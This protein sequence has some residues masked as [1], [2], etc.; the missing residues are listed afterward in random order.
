LVPSDF[1][2]F[3]R[4]CAKAFSPDLSWFNH[5]YNLK[6]T[7]VGKVVSERRNEK[8]KLVA[9]LSNDS[10]KLKHDLK[11]AHASNLELENRITELADSLKKCQEE[12]KLAEA[13]LRDSKK[14]HEKL[15]KI[16]EDDLKMTENLHRDVDKSTTTID[17]LRSTNVEIS[18]KNTEL[19]KTLSMKEQA[20]LDLEKA[21]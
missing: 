3:G 11:K 18:T 14:D 5:I 9:K 12:K 20:I 1:R 2:G 21:C 16:R 15:N 17:E 4:K 10:Q 7:I 19:A 8:E 13:A 6:T